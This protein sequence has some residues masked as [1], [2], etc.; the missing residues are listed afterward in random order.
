[1]E[2]RPSLFHYVGHLH[3]VLS[4]FIASTGLSVAALAWGALRAALGLGCPVAAP[5]LALVV[6]LP[7]HHP[8]DFDTV[9][10]LGLVH[11]ATVVFL[12][13]ALLALPRS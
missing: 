4:G 9:G 3:I 6:A 12:V 10:H 8:N 5:V 13:G 2:F 11:Q 1:M 7:A